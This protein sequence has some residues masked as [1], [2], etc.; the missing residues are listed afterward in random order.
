[1]LWSKNYLITERIGPRAPVVSSLYEDDVLLSLDPLI[2]GPQGQGE[3]E[4]E[5]RW[6]LALDSLILWVFTSLWTVRTSGHGSH[7]DFCISEE[8]WIDFH[9][10]CTNH[11]LACTDLSGPCLFDLPH[12]RWGDRASTTHTPSGPRRKIQGSGKCSQGC[13]TWKE[14]GCLLPELARQ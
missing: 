11:Q 1:M 6:W 9:C 14:R 7:S 12:P 13:S 8:C 3:G 4:L 5:L 2:Q 10:K